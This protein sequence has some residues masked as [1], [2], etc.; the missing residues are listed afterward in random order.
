LALLGLIGRY[1]SIRP[2]AENHFFETVVE[3]F[4]INILIGILLFLV[5][6]AIKQVRD[7]FGQGEV[8]SDDE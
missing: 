4:A 6:P 8:K 7:A 3:F 5:A 1:F 2:D